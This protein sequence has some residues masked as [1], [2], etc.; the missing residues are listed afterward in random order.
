MRKLIAFAFAALAVVAF[1][2][3]QSMQAEAQIIDFD[4][5][6]KASFDKQLATNKPLIV[7][8]N[9]TW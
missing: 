3:Y 7:H 2:G 8:V 4:I 1:M 5:Y 6:D 9:T